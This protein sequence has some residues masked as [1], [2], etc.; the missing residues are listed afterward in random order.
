MYVIMTINICQCDD[1]FPQR[2]HVEHH[3]KTFQHSKNGKQRSRTRTRT[4]TG[5][6]GGMISQMSLGLQG[7]TDYLLFT[8]FFR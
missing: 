6:A 2:N 5:R 3:T 7:V 4:R 8:Y 1:F